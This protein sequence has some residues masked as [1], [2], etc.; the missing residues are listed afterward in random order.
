MPMDTS[1]PAQVPIRRN[2]PL[3]DHAAIGLADHEHRHQCPLRLLQLQAEGQ[4]Q[5]QPAGQ[6]GLHRELQF[7]QARHS[8]TCTRSE[9]KKEGLAIADAPKYM[10][11]RIISKLIF[12]CPAFPRTFRKSVSPCETCATEAH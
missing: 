11:E 10:S 1:A 9:E 5:G 2:M 7:V 6:Q 3:Q 12:Y 8:S 4:V